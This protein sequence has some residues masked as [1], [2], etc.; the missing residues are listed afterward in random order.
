M[1]FEDEAL[2]LINEQNLNSKCNNYIF[3]DIDNINK[4]KLGI[5]KIS[6]IS[7][8]RYFQM[9]D[10]GDNKLHNVL[11]DFNKIK[12]NDVLANALYELAIPNNIIYKELRDLLF[13]RT[14]L[15]KLNSN[16][17]FIMLNSDKLS[18]DDTKL[19]NYLIYFKTYFFNE[20]LL[21][22]HDEDLKT[23]QTF[24]GNVLDYREN[25]QKIRIMKRSVKK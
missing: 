16:V 2:D 18:L 22:G 17:Q 1:I 19:L 21:F 15:R 9:E 25:Y 13:F 3:Y 7:N 20:I 5:K 24:N 23:Y 8:Y 11:V 4:F 6:S 14:V 10:I 12:I